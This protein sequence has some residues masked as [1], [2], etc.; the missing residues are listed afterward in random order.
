LAKSE[1][2]PQ[3]AI[4]GRA[5]CIKSN[6]P[7]PNNETISGNEVAP[8]FEPKIIPRA[9]LKEIIPAL[10]NAIARRV[11]I[12]P[13][14]LI[15]SVVNHPAITASIVVRVYFCRISLSLFPATA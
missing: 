12:S 9:L 13:L 11:T 6:F 3:I 4:S 15:R 5:I 8:I 2:N 1:T 14:Q 10:T 7:K